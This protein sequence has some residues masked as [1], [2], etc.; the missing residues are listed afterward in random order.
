MY[1]RMC[2]AGP[3]KVCEVYLEMN[4]D[5]AAE[6]YKSFKH[7]GD[8]SH[9]F[10]SSKLPNTVI[11]KKDADV[12]NQLPT[13]MNQLFVQRMKEGQYE[14]PKNAPPNFLQLPFSMQSDILN[15]EAGASIGRG[16][17]TPSAELFGVPFPHANAAVTA[18]CKEN[19]QM[20]ITSTKVYVASFCAAMSVF[21]AHG[22]TLDSLLA[23][24][25]SGKVSEMMAS[26][27]MTFISALHTLPAT[28]TYGYDI[29]ILKMPGKCYFFVCML[30]FL[31]CA[32]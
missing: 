32:F 23:E 26:F 3:L 12:V 22:M 24:C 15:K 27:S 21:A 20:N 4:K 17:T 16:G 29:M 30:F 1:V 14:M 7:G 2:W 31:D 25:N 9:L 8:K 5:K 19:E 28:Q 11:S 13:V 10:T 18:M 6:L